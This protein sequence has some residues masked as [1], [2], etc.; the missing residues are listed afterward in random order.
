MEQKGG[1]GDKI[2]ME[3][4]S[5]YNDDDIS[6]ENGKLNSIFVHYQKPEALS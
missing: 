5:L 3:L 4:T 1:E 2:K 6:I